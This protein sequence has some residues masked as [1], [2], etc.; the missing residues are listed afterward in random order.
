MKQFLM[1]DEYSS[2][3]NRQPLGLI[4]NITLI[5]PSSSSKNDTITTIYI[6]TFAL[7]YT[8]AHIDTSRA[9]TKGQNL[10][11]VSVGR[12]LEPV[13]YKGTDLAKAGTTQPFVDALDTCMQFWSTFGCKFDINESA[14]TA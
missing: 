6:S 8:I 4:S 13:F 1:T 2:D 9:V 12:I 5:Q 3:S 11:S 14:S 10:A 7:K